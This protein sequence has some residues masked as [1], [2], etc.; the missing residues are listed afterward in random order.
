MEAYET[1]GHGEKVDVDGMKPYEGAIRSDDQVDGDH[2][3][4]IQY[5]V[6]AS[7]ATQVNSPPASN[8]HIEQDISLSEN[9][10]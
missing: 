2:N 5:E 10:K 7:T 3:A 9:S 4:Q 1:H 6:T 8:D